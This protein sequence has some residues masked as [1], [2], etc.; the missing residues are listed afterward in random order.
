MKYTDPQELYR[1]ELRRKLPRATL[2]ADSGTSALAAIKLHCLECVGENSHREVEE[3]PS[4]GCFLYPYR[5]GKTPNP[6]RRTEHPGRFKSEDQGDDQ[7][8]ESTETMLDD[9]TQDA[10][11]ASGGSN[12]QGTTS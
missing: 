5:H 9:S 7:D 4:H 12:P 3:C 6:G 2:R 8:E 11:Q 10:S 1:D